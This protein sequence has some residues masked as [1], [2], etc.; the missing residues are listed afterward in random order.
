MSPERNNLLRALEEAVI[1]AA[2]HLKSAISTGAAV[3]VKMKGDNTLVMNLDLELQSIMM[4]IL[5]PHLPVVA[6][7]DE[8][9]HPLIDRHSSYFLVDP[10]DGTTTCKRFMHAA[11]GQVGFGPLA[12]VVIDGKVAACV[13]CN[14]PEAILYTAVRGEGC[15]SAPFR[16]TGDVLPLAT[17]RRLTAD[18][19]APLSEA[20]VL[21]YAGKRGEMK[22][23]EFLRNEN[24]VENA[25]RFGGFANDC[26]RLSRGYEQILVQ[27][28]VR[29]WDFAA[30]L[31][32]I[33]AG[34]GAVVDPH[35]GAAKFHEWTL[36]MN[37]PVLIAPPA[38]LPELT[39][40]V[41]SQF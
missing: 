6:E 11:A 12:G 20:G 17:R 28:S 3:H 1:A 15:F 4:P 37:N 35:G 8:S 40:I 36:R 5:V 22:I 32:A 23:V 25:Y 34:Y 19:T 30:I 27:F 26:A 14:L 39:K 10:L 33:E 7:E 16:E 21:F 31:L 9:T 29:P 38:L 24:L 18:V 2:R 13:Y 41:R